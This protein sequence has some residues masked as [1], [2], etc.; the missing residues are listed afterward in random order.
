M[1]M[2]DRGF[3]AVGAAGLGAA[4]IL[5]GTAGGAPAKRG[6]PPPPLTTLQLMRANVEIPA[7]GIWAAATAKSLSDQDWALAEQDAMNII[8]SATF[9]A[10][11][12]NTAKD[13]AK[14]LKADYQGWAREVQATGI[15]ILAA[16]K[17]KDQM[18]MSEAGDRLV[19]VCQ[20]CHDKYRP[21]IP[22]DGVQRFPFYPA[23]ALKP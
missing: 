5:A 13:K 17:A 21:E 8:A 3:W 4:L 16:A 6:L 23:R 10:A 2:G 18:K 7:D 1:S 20:S 11:G 14:T 9:I 12:G 19:D 15:K 22:S